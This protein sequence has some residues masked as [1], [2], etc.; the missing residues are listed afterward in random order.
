VTIEY[1]AKGILSLP[2]SLIY[3]Q[4]TIQETLTTQV[5]IKTS[6]PPSLE[7]VRILNSDN[8][9]YLIEIPRYKSGSSIL[10]QL[11][12]LGID[13]KSIENNR[14]IQ[15]DLILPLD[16]PLN[17][18]GAKFLYQ[19]PTIEGKAIASYEIPVDMLGMM[20]RHLSQENVTIDLIHDF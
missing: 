8:D 16:T 9:F 13:F 1:S 6:S 19:V 11:G 7:K 14:R 15:I 17:I 20:I 4:P 5:L 10:Q 2:L 12:L 3:T 18:P